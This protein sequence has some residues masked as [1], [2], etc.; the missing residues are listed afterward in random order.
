[1]T[2]E[3]I[4][5]TTSLQDVSSIGTDRMLRVRGAS[6]D[7]VLH[8][9]G[10]EASDADSTVRLLTLAGASD[11]VPLA[12]DTPFARYE[13]AAGKLGTGTVSI[14][15]PAAETSAEKLVLSASLQDASGIGAGRR[16]SV[17]GG[18]DDLVVAI[19]GAEAADADSTVRIAT[20]T[21]GSRTVP[22][23]SDATPFVRYQILAGSLGTGKV[24]VTG[25]ASAAAAPA[26]AETVGVAS[27]AALAAVGTDLADGTVAMVEGPRASRWTLMT[28]PAPD[29]TAGASATWV[30]YALADDGRVW[31]RDLAIGTPGAARQ[32]IW[33][34]DPTSGNDAADGN[35]PGTA[36][37]T[38]DE[39]LARIG[40]Q[41]IAIAITVTIL[42]DLPGRNTSD[43]P[44][45]NY[46]IRLNTEGTASGITFIGG[47]TVVDTYSVSTA[48][49]WADATQTRGEYTLTGLP[50]LVG[51]SLEERWVKIS[52]GARDGAE[53]QLVNATALGA[54]CANFHKASTW[55]DVEPQVGDTIQ[56]CDPMSFGN[57]PVTVEVNGLGSVTFEHFEIGKLFEFHSVVVARGK[58]MFKGCRLRGLDV[59]RDAY[60]TLSACSTYH[61]TSY[62]ELDMYGGA[63]FSSPITAARS[64][65]INTS[66]R[67]CTRLFGISVGTST[68]GPGHFQI[69][70][71]APV[72]ILDA[73]N[74]VGVQIHAGSTLSAEDHCWLKSPAAVAL[75]FHVYEGAVLAYEAGKEPAGS[76]A[77]I[78]YARI[79][80]TVKTSAEIPYSGDGAAFVVLQ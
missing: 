75:G 55:S 3:K 6:A 34:I 57:V 39:L 67:F 17:R 12:D 78:E 15:G 64:G 71:G 46:T 20:L 76:P 47:T 72:A 69:Q 50:N 13:V 1:M 8:I 65:V 7:L 54:F 68:D 60:V 58:A 2:V 16:Y 22:V 62:G 19:L 32:A 73:S 36:L 63:H 80:G 59:G 30:N 26:P 33:Y 52:G 70:A 38:L 23:P 5:L 29:E 31:V 10:A 11:T 14:S 66:S 44:G 28:M 35:T 41:T 56:F 40:E 48:T 27:T 43:W 37:R 24:W 49:A 18:S 9:L 77:P 42:G 79:G 21:G 53:A 4:V 45:G 61:C 51:L 25:P 74:G